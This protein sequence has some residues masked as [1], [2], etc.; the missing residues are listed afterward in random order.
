MMWLQEQHILTPDSKI[1]VYE[2]MGSRY[3]N[4]TDQQN[5]TDGEVVSCW[6]VSTE[7]AMHGLLHVGGSCPG[8]R[9]PIISMA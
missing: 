3:N 9:S 5:I 8:G 4:Y 6:L 1:G 7:T 2:F